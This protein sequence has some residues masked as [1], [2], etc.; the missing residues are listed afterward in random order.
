M[1]I[2]ASLFMVSSILSVGQV[3]ANELGW[4]DDIKKQMT[5]GCVLG[6]LKP[7]K[8]DFQARAAQ[9]GD[10]NAVFPVETVRPSIAALCACITERVAVSWS[11]QQFLGQPHLADQLITEA[12]SGGQCK[13]TGMLGKALGSSQ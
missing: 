7:A 12:L 2:Q 11:Y 13:P 1:K 10:P 8:R 6:I 4:T 9:R 5:D 3:T